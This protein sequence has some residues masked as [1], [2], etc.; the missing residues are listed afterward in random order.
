MQFSVTLQIANTILTH[1]QHDLLDFVF[2]LNWPFRVNLINGDY[3]YIGG[4]IRSHIEQ[5]LHTTMTY[6]N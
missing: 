3:V 2:E 5:H 1:L 4:M 6:K